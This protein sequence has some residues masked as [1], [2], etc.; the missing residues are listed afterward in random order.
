MLTLVSFFNAKLKVLYQT[1]ES[2]VGFE[3]LIAVVVKSTIGD[4]TLCCPLKVFWRNI[5][6]PFS[7]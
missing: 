4:I 2:N 7:E 3:V 6:P 5:S 1:L